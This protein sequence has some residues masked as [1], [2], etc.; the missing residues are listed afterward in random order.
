[1]YRVKIGVRAVT[2]Y[3]VC[4]KDE[5]NSSCI[6]VVE[7]CWYVPALQQILQIICERVRISEIDVKS[8]AC[9]L[10]V[11][12]SSSSFNKCGMSKKAGFMLN[13]IYT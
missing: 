4:F 6:F 10:S 7:N 1:M 13:L 3:T 9:I 12:P 11:K 8:C 5:N 2:T